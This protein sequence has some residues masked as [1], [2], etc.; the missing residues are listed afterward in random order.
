[1]SSQKTFLV[2]SS[3][4]VSA[5]NHCHGDSPQLRS[6]RHPRLCNAECWTATARA[7]HMGPHRIQTCCRPSVTLTL[8][9]YPNSPQAV[10]AVEASMLACQSAIPVLQGLLDAAYKTDWLLHWDE[11]SFQVHQHPMKSIVNSW[12]ITSGTW[13]KNKQNL[14]FRHIFVNWITQAGRLLPLDAFFFQLTGISYKLRYA[15]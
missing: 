14:K 11:Y 3:K 9:T 8:L 1:M 12:A 2:K 10:M 7:A 6:T 5:A 15:G 4:A 13:K